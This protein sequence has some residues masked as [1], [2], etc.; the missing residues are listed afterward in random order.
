MLH[1]R[2]SCFPRRQGT[3]ARITGSLATNIELVKSTARLVN[4]IA[5]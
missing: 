1:R 2:I 3:T 4:A 5:G